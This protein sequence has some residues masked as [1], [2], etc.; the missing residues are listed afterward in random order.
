MLVSPSVE[1]LG[2]LVKH[3]I[4]NLFFI[5]EY[6]A[7]AVLAS[8]SAALENTEYCFSFSKNKYYKK[9]GCVFFSIYHS[10]QYCIFLYFLA[11]QVISDF[12]A[13]RDLADKIYFLNKALNGLDLY[14][15]V[16]MP[17]VFNLDHPVGSVMGRADYGENFTFS[18]LCTVGNNKGVFPEI[19]ENV[20]MFSGAKILGR[21][22]IG[23]DVIISANSYIKDENVPSNSL[24]FG[25]SPSLVIKPRKG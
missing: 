9:N 22:K 5:D 6:E 10:G 16:V 3:Q 25:S 1:M 19:G 11:R 8:L 12:P 23:D 7:D 20:Q 21:C 2:K 24:V 14:Y 17:K 13:L 15:E 4:H 18:Q